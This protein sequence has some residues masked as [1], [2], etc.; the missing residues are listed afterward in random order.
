MIKMGERRTEL[1]KCLC[2]TNREAGPFALHPQDSVVRRTEAIPVTGEL[3]ATNEKPE[4]D[5]L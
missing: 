4:S 2:L 5:R 1:L 3:R